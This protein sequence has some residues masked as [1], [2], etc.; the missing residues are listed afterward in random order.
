LAQ[1]YT[2]L[3]CSEAWLPDSPCLVQRL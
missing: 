1:A 3:T 2:G